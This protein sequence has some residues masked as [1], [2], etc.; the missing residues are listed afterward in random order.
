MRPAPAAVVFVRVP[1]RVHGVPENSST[2]TGTCTAAVRAA[3]GI[4]VGGPAGGGESVLSR[5]KTGGMAGAEEVRRPA[6]N[7]EFASFRSFA[8]FA[9]LTRGLQ[10]PI[11]ACFCGYAGC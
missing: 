4:D 10:V 7:D 2:C 6:P 11:L 8:D 1:V 3:I 5:P 9:G